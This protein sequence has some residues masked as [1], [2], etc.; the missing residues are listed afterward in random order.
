[1]DSTDLIINDPELTYTEQ[2]SVLRIDQ[3][4]DYRSLRMDRY[5]D[6]STGDH[7]HRRDQSERTVMKDQDRV[8]KRSSNSVHQGGEDTRYTEHMT[9]RTNQ[10]EFKRRSSLRRHKVEESSL[11][12]K[13]QDRDRLEGE[14]R[15]TRTS[16]TLNC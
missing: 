7:K 10:D 13:R 6:R 1:M 15:R 11:K 14:T 2:R 16:K 5:S 12:D 3:D 4:L 9:N 8:G